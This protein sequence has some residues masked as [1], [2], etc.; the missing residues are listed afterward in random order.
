MGGRSDDDEGGDDNGGSYGK[1]ELRMRVV[2][3]LELLLVTVDVE[4]KV[5][6]GVEVVTVKM[7]GVA[8]MGEIVAVM[9]GVGVVGEAEVGVEKVDVAKQYGNVCSNRIAGT[10]S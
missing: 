1:N 5:V 9:V 2:E 3:L 4:V 10:H 8:E 7:E 6:V